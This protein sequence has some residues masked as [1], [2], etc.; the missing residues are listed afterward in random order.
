MAVAVAITPASVQYGGELTVATTGLEVDT[1]YTMV[2]SRPAG[3]TATLD[4]VSDGSGEH[5]VTISVNGRGTYTVEYFALPVSQGTA[6]A[7]GV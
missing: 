1:A 2:V 6:S 4:V 7:I 3:R 5:T